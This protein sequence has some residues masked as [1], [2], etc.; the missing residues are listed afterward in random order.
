MRSHVAIATI[1]MSLDGNATT[2]DAHNATTN[3]TLQR[4]GMEATAAMMVVTL[5]SAG[6]QARRGLQVMGYA[7]TD[8]TIGSLWPSGSGAIGECKNE[9]A[10]FDCPNS[11]ATY[12]VIGTWDTSSVTIMDYRTS[13]CSCSPPP[14]FTR[15]CES[16]PPSCV[17][18]R[19]E[20]RVTLVHAG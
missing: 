7:M 15:T 17:T 13:T 6:A 14:F 8:A 18:R 12:G 5:P 20:R 9:N 16:D 2:V 3:G 1:A 4:S 11:Q 10:A 19:H